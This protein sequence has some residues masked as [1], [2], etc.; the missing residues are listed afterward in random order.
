[1]GKTRRKKRRTHI[2]AEES[3]DPNAPPAPKSFVFKSGK[4]GKSVSR[5][6]KDMRKVM[7]PQTAIKLKRKHNKVKDFLSVAGQ[8][9]V[10]Q[11]LIFTQTD[12]GT[13][14]RLARTPRGPT[15]CFRVLKY[16]LIG[17]VLSTQINPKS[18]KSEFKTSPLVVLNN[19]GG[20]ENHMKLMTSMLQN[21]FPSININKMQLAE[22]RRV[23]MFN[24]D[25]ETKNIDFR[26]YCIGVKPV[27]ISKSVRRIVTNNIPDLS[28]YQDISHVSESE[29]ES[30]I[31][32]TVTLAQDFI[33]KI[34]KKS[35]QRAI[36][37]TEIGPRMELKLV[38]IQAELCAGEV[39]FHEFKEIKKMNQEREQRR[40]LKQMRRKEQERNV[41]RKKLE[42]EAHRLVTSDSCESINDNDEDDIYKNRIN[43][44]YIMEGDDELFKEDLND[45]NDFEEEEGDENESSSEE[46]ETKLQLSSKSNWKNS[47]QQRKNN[48]MKGKPKMSIKVGVKKRKRK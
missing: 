23:V 16:S 2:P 30:G 7:E 26:H 48:F 33:G 32:T 4:V 3:V 12:N 13:N 15:L 19:F 11:F 35:D 40:K 29:A 31:E 37:L 44:E 39:L 25:P 38:K 1:M 36:K 18:P 42:K 5:L 43:D 47:H 9:G 6:V 8:I 10:T 27:G 14:L 45:Y 21:M 34:N 24:Y 17:D 46:N 22:A 41:E 20:E 28:N